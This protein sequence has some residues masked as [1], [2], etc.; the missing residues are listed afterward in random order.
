MRLI[1][2]VNCKIWGLWD[3]RINPAT[4]S[5]TRCECRQWHHW[6][7][8]H[9]PQMP[10]T[11][12]RRNSFLFWETHN[13]SV[14][15]FFICNDFDYLNSSLQQYYEPVKITYLSTDWRYKAHSLSY[16]FVNAK[17]LPRQSVNVSVFPAVF[18]MMTSWRAFIVAAGC[19]HQHLHGPPH[20]NPT[21]PFGPRSWLQT[22]C[23]GPRHDRLDSDLI[24]NSLQRHSRHTTVFCTYSKYHKL[25]LCAVLPRRSWVW[26]VPTESVE[27]CSPLALALIRLKRG[28]PGMLW[29]MNEPAKASF[30]V[31]RRPL[32][33]KVI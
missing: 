1:L 21:F 5:L 12:T 6:V 20:E 13:L 7:L 15:V 24:L 16:D 28:S 4:S 3:S 14:C 31:I 32:T 23:Q 11:F 10:M 19:S 30:W 26:R 8:A 29:H 22:L 2:I 9:T 25:V 17:A 18:V 27:P 33:L